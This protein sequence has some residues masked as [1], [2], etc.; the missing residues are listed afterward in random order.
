[1]T[2]RV[3]L[4]NNGRNPWDPWKVI[5]QEKNNSVWEAT[6]KVA[7]AADGRKIPYDVTKI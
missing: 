1:M 6:L 5:F 4:D 3:W 2:R 7:N